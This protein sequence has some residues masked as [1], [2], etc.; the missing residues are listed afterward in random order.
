MTASVR[1]GSIWGIPIGLHWSLLFVFS[2]LVWSLG[3]SAF[4]E[5]YPSLGPGRSYLLA[6]VTGVL[7][8]GSI[9]LHELGHARV[10]LR[11]GVPVNGITL[12]IFGGVAEIGAAAK[13]PGAEFRIAAGGPIVSLAL[14]LLFQGLFMVDRSVAALAA[15]SEWLARINL[16]LL[17]FNL[18]PGYA[19]DGGRMLRA[20]VWKFSD[21]EATGWKAAM[22]SGQIVSLGMIAIGIYRAIGGD[23]ANGIWLVFIGWFL[24]NAT[25][26]ENAAKTIQS[27]LTGATAGE[28]MRMTEEPRVPSRMKLRQLI[29]EHVLTHG[30]NYFL[31]VDD[32]IPRGVITLPDIVAIPRDKWDWTSVAEV[33]TPWSRLVRIEPDVDLLDAMRQMDA[34]G[35][36]HMPVCKGD[37]LLGLLTRE[38]VIRF[39]RLRAELGPAA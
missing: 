11:E 12:F 39:M 9:L 16:M 25:A 31:V 37:T 13:T 18:I 32:E 33:M 19:L 28:A 7:F 21:S 22:I 6:A 23:V 3:G 26:A 10:A 34:G 2:F 35:F 27:Q 15:P 29:D 20:A 1:L 30:S 36:G 38:E 5:A 24:Q 14:F 17:L 4:P 8:F